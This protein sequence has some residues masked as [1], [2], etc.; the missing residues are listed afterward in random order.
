MN[1]VSLHHAIFTSPDL[2]AHEKFGL[3]FGLK[4]VQRSPD[5]LIMRAP[6]GI[7]AYNYIVRKAD[8]ATFIGLGFTVAGRDDLDHAVEHLGGTAIR[9]V[10]RPGGGLITTILGPEGIQ[11]ELIAGEQPSSAEP[12][13]P[14]LVINSPILSNR[15]NEVL[16]FRPIGPQ[17]LFSLGHVALYVR[18]LK[19]AIATLQDVL[20]MK[21][22]DAAHLGNPEEPI[23][24]FMR[25]DRGAEP[26]EHHTI[27]LVEYKRT[28]CHHM[29][30]QAQDFE[31]QFTA[32]RWLQTQGYRPVAGVGRHGL[33]CHIYDTWYGPDSCMWETYS[34]TD[35]VDADWPRRDHYAVG[36]GKLDVWRDDPDENARYFRLGAYAEADA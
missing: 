10:E 19:L 14:E 30:F 1:V 24:A 20:G 27:A 26:T 15:L 23:V 32:H 4:T 22:T 18:D 2:D 16:N 29:S 7:D 21:V 9:A 31:A 3:D 8:R 25:L 17:K 28:D 6:C 11:F 35:L 34:D 13:Y 5:E 33:G 12:E 36:A